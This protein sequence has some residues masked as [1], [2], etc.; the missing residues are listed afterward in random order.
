[1]LRWQR[2]RRGGC[3][4]RKRVRFATLCLDFAP[5]FFESHARQSP[6]QISLTLFHK[7]GLKARGNS[8]LVVLG[9][10]FCFFGQRGKGRERRR[11]A[12]AGHRNIT[13]GKVLVMCGRPRFR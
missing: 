13:A 6:D 2:W 3:D 12:C 10:G 4:G 8:P 11:R 1:M 5:R 7:V 9:G